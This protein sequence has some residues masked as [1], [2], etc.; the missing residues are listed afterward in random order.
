MDLESATALPLPR[1]AA[2][3]RLVGEFDYSNA[4]DISDAVCEALDRG[5]DA[6]RLQLDE[7]DF[8]SAAA[9]G[10]IVRS[11]NSCRR[12]GSLLGVVCGQPRLRRLFV[13]TGLDDLLVPPS[14]DERTGTATPPFT[15]TVDARRER[16]T[17]PPARRRTRPGRG[18]PVEV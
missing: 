9:I 1:C 6:V 3:I 10:A 18:L 11:R 17:E 7:V 14:S 8:I 5:A 13:I 15:W 4:R 12:Q 2:T 16:G